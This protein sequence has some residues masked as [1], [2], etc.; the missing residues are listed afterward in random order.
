M[1]QQIYN[2]YSPQYGYLYQN[3]V[4]QA[5]RPVYSNT[6]YLPVQPQPQPQINS[7]APVMRHF[8]QQIPGVLYQNYNNPGTNQVTGQIFSQP[9][10][11][12]AYYTPQIQQLPP[13]P[14]VSQQEEIQNIDHCPWVQDPELKLALNKLA[15]IKHDPQDIEYLKSI[16]ITPPFNSGKEALDFIVQNQIKVTFTDF[17][18]SAAH[19]QYDD[20]N[21]TMSINQNYKGKM[22]L[23]MA[24][25]MA[26]ALYHEAGHAKDKDSISS[27]QEELNCLALNVLGYRY[28]Q[29]TYPDIINSNSGAS[30]LINDG[31]ALYPKLFFDNDPAK[32]A[33]INRVTEKYGFLPMESPNH[34]ISQKPL[35]LLVKSQYAQQQV[36]PRGPLQA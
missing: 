26:D 8:I 4:R 21:K 18:N 28:Q 34:R 9:M 20:A 29:R 35:A 17:G 24:L 31:V 15:E 12:Q 7:P 32:K 27:I 13:A 2:N 11:N 6:A 5:Q 19:A 36:Q 14:P 22:T 25:A 1:A 16:G 3:Q 23:P 33:L 30:R 10:N